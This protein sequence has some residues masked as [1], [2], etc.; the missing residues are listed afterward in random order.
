M[1]SMVSDLTTPVEITLTN[2]FVADHAESDAL[3]SKTVYGAAINDVRVETVERDNY[4]TDNG[5]LT[6]QL[7]ASNSAFKLAAGE[8]VKITTTKSREVA[9]FEN[10]ASQLATLDITVEEKAAEPAGSEG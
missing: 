6:I 3:A 7:F 5:E 2:T 8:F 10:V 9:Y 4:F 1:Y